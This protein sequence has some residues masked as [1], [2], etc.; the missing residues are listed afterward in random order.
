MAG[1]CFSSDAMAQPFCISVCM[2]IIISN[3]ADRWAYREKRG[4]WLQAA[5]KTNKI[6]IQTGKKQRI[7]YID[8]AKG[9]C[10][11][12]VVLS[13]ILAFYRTSLPYD[14]VLKCFRMPLYFFLSGVFFK[15]YENFLG[16]FKRK[17]NKLLI[18]FLFF[19]VTLGL[20]LPEV[21]YKYGVKILMYIQNI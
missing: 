20:L 16:F 11:L 19:F 4:L 3:F 10:I 13:H 17:I 21:L 12:L 15:Q 2:S 6:V 1:L 5:N 8:L 14:S 18:P 7:E 9:F